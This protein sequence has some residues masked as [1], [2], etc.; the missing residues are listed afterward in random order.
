MPQ[1]RR[2]TG[3]RIARYYDRNTARFLLVGGSGRSR[4]LHRQLWGEGITS[5]EGASSYINRI[6]EA[7]VRAIHRTDAPVILDMGCGV[8]GTLLHLAEEWPEGRFVGITISPKQHC[9]AERLAAQRNLGERCRFVLGDFERDET[10]VVADAIVAIESLAHS[11]SRPDFF[12][13]ASRQLAAGGSLLIADDFLAEEPGTLDA[14]VRRQIED[15]RIG[16]RLPGLGTV[17]ACVRIASERGLDLASDADL[18]GLIRVGR[19]RDRAIAL[20]G[21]LIRRLGLHEVP[22][23]GNMIGGNALQNGLREGFISYRFLC[24]RK[25]AGDERKPASPPGASGIRAPA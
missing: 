4:A 10:G 14:A 5:T 12:A 11:R 2:P 7:V 16:W 22:F 1:P 20:L 6:V 18:T 15:F 25:G 21:P 13:A 8:G 19:P 3:D 17:G 9:V 23:F 24:F